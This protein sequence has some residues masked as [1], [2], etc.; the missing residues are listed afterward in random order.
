MSGDRRRRRT[1]W[2]RSADAGAAGAAGHA[3][4]ARSADAD[5]ARRI[6]LYPEILRFFGD[7][8]ED[9]WRELTPE[10]SE[11]LLE[12]LAPPATA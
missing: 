11:D 3:A 9:E 8:P 7:Q 1:T 4:S 12:A 6:G 5:A 10:E 2:S